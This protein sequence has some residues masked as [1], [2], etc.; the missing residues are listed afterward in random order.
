MEDS[1]IIIMVGGPGKRLWPLSTKELPKPFLALRTNKPLIEE[2]VERIIDICP[3]ER[4]RF[5]LQEEHKNLA[6]KIFPWTKRE[7]YI[8]EPEGKDT[9]AAIF[10]ALLNLPPNATAIVLSSDHWISDKLSFQK[11]LMLAI[12]FLKEH[13]DFILTFGIAPKRPETE[14]GYIKKEKELARRDG[15]RISK[16]AR[17]VEKP[18]LKT[19]K[20]YIKNKDYF[21]N[22]GIF[23]F[24]KE[25]MEGLIKLYLP[26][27]F[28][29]IKGKNPEAFKT[30]KKI[31]IDH[32]VMEHIKTIAMIEADF[33][34]DDIGGYESLLRIHKKDANN[35]LIFGNHKVISTKDCIIYS[36]DTNIKTIGISNIVIACSKGNLLVASKDRLNKIKEL[37]D[38][39]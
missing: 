30:L 23:I 22:S 5:V 38:I 3:K 13:P 19:A 29:V 25:R 24:K 26:E 34:W 37:V 32:G 4:I 33:L 1:Y 15:I 35:N 16:V 20:S 31:S 18:T 27:H 17:F 14:Y 7:N 21:W 6:S 28:K 36:K 39:E 10:L 12:T 11:G 9:A 2:T 8:I